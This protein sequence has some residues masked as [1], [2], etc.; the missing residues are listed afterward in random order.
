MRLRFWKALC[1]ERGS[2]ELTSQELG[3]EGTKP[4]NASSVRGLLNLMDI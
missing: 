2:L 3:L 4:A 1:Q